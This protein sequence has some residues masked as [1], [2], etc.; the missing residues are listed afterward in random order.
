MIQSVIN[1]Q[2]SVAMKQAELDFF[3][4]LEKI[5]GKVRPNY[6]K[7]IKS[8]MSENV[9]SCQTNDSLNVPL[10][11]GGYV[12]DGSAGYRNTNKQFNGWFTIVRISRYLG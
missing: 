9:Y 5:K 6:K 3:T 2:D 8:L 12:N 4:E 11:Y 10:G 1:I 7:A